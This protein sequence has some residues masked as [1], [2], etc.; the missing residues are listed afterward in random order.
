M[1]K[2]PKSKI[3]GTNSIYPRKE[4]SLFPVSEGGNLPNE[5]MNRV[6]WEIL[7]KR[8]GYQELCKGIKFYDRTGLP[9]MWHLKPENQE[10][11]FK[12]RNR[13][14]EL[15]SIEELVDPEKDYSELQ[16]DIVNLFGIA[17]KLVSAIA[18]AD[19]PPGPRQ[20]IQDD[21]YVTLRIDITERYDYI[22]PLIKIHLDHFRGQV[23]QKEG[24][25]HYEKQ[26]RY[27]KIW[28]ELLNGEQIATI[29]IK[30]NISL[31][32][33]KNGYR[34]AFELITG[35]KYDK[36]VLRQ[37]II[38]KLKKDRNFKRLLDFEEKAET[39]GRRID[40]DDDVRDDNISIFNDT[41]AKLL[42]DDILKVFCQSCGNEEC[43]TLFLNGDIEVMK[44]CANVVKFLIE[45]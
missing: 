32:K 3:V 9:S 17:P 35:K 36:E 7:R 24:R 26:L 2:K 19:A 22:E 12:T 33:A 1:E 16:P 27:L 41:E 39:E 30:L 13:A 4:I 8:P 37:L 10:D 15:F 23:K 11:Y 42:I 21:R 34:R 29:A 18:P 31:D 6:F 5:T 44:D 14:R 20:F 45:P 43:K 40:D 25:E 38:E 28:D